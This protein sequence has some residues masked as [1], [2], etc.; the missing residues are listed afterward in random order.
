MSAAVVTLVGAWIRLIS[1]LYPEGQFWWV[2][3]GQGLIG[4]GSPLLVGGL[5]IIANQWFGDNERGKA[6][7]IMTLANPIG[8]LLGFIIQGV[9]AGVMYEESKGL[10]FDSTE[11]AHIVRENIYLMLFIENIAITVM[12]LYFFLFFRSSAPPTPPSFAAMRNRS[13]I[14]QG[15]VE[16]FKILMRNRNFML[17]TICYMFVFSIYAGIGAILPLLFGPLGFG[18]F[19]DSVFGA[20]FV[21]CGAVACYAMG[22]YLDRTNKYISA[23]RYVLG[24]T[25]GLFTISIYLIPTG[26]F[27]CEIIWSVAAGIFMVPIVPVGFSFASEVTHPVAPA[28]VIGLMTTFANILCFSL[29]FFYLSVLSDGTT[30]SVRS[31]IIV[32]AVEAGLAVLASIPIRED[33]RRLDSVASM[34][35]MYSD[36]TN[37]PKSARSKKSKAKLVSSHSSVQVED[38][39]GLVTPKPEEEQQA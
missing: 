2:V 26:F 25:F 17:I 34:S 31:V 37:S 1:Q 13:S 3:A 38:E 12:V 5:S 21:L 8:M 7:G 18:P 11:T 35:M 6:T 20:I 19:A 36:R 10:P 30:S 27:Y 16:D 28:M 4:I 32:F 22:A 23:L 33:L 24:A 39:D 29:N 9:F 15:M 14:T